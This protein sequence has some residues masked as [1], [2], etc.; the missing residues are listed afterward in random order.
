MARRRID[1]LDEKVS[2]QFV[3]LVGLQATTLAATVGAMATI[4]AVL[5]A[6]A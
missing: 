2:R 1:V 6:R 3:W 5:L 4:V